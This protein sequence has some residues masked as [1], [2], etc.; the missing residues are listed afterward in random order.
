[1]VNRAQLYDL[2]DRAIPLREVYGAYGTRVDSTADLVSRPN[3]ALGAGGVHL[4]TVPIAYSENVRV[5]VDELARRVPTQSE[6]M[7]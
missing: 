4:V 2:L 5:L 1:M 3:A 6:V 7:A